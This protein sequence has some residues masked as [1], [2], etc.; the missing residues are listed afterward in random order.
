MRAHVTGAAAAAA[1]ALGFAAGFSW[2]P[3]SAGAAASDVNTPILKSINRQ[4]T[5][6]NTSVGRTRKEGIW[7]EVEDAKDFLRMIE[8]NTR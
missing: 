4:L 2:N 5:T 6:L 7:N 1:A 3:D 8:R